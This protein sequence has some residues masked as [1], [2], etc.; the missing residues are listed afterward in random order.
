M[1]FS[2]ALKSFSVVLALFCIALVPFFVRRDPAPVHSIVHIEA[3]P[4][5]EW[6]SLL[7]R[8]GS[9]TLLASFVLL[10]GGCYLLIKG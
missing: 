2:F 10:V 9:A 4:R 3:L 5:P 1:D 6:P 7:T 8:M